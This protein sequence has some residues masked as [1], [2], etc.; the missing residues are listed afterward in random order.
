MCDL[1]NKEYQELNIILKESKNALSKCFKPDLFNYATLGNCVRHHHWHIIP[2]YKSQRIIN[3]I[4]FKD[5]N[6]NQPPWPYP[7]NKIDKKTMKNIKEL[8]LKR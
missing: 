8:I 6:W 1:K 5:D 7:I 3:K 2:R 4:I